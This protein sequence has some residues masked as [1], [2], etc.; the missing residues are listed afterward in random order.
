MAL[1]SMIQKFAHASEMRESMDEI[2]MG[3][4]IAVMTDAGYPVTGMLSNNDYQRV[5]FRALPDPLLHTV[6]LTLDRKTAGLTA[7]VVGNWA[8]LT[9]QAEVKNYLADPDDLLAMYNTGIKNILKIPLL[10]DVKMSHQFN[11]VFGTKKEKFQIEKLTD[12]SQ[13]LAGFEDI[14]KMIFGCLDELKDKLKEHKKESVLE[15]K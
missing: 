13:P 1:F 3:K 12:L 9:I 7:K 2:L 14:H 6:T 10:G 8:F 5:Q 11:S 4:I 15:P